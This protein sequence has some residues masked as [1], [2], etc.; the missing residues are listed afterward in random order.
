MSVGEEAV[1]LANPRATSL[2]NDVPK[3]YRPYGTS[4]RELLVACMG[5]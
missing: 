2:Y 4:S 1:S 5:K 3:T